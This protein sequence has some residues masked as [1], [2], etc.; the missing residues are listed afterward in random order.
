M[1]ICD[2]KF[3]VYGFFAEH[4]LSVNAAFILA[5]RIG[6]NPVIELVGVRETLGKCL[7]EGVK[8]LRWRFRAQAQP[9]N[10]AANRRSRLQQGRP[11]SERRNLFR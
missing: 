7:V 3:A 6:S 4:S 10:L 2:Y 1:R 5:E 11:Q 9:N 8:W